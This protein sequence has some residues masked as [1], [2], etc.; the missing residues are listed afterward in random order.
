MVWRERKANLLAA[1]SGKLF[2][3]Q[4]KGWVLG[5]AIGL[6]HHEVPGVLLGFILIDVEAA[7]PFPLPLHTFQGKLARRC[8]FTR[9]LPLR[10]AAE[11]LTGDST[12]VFRFSEISLKGMVHFNAE[13]ASF[14]RHADHPRRTVRRRRRRD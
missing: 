13:P 2:L 4:P 14:S 1:P 7:R 12:G 10:E 5:F 8:F 6:P 11:P 9:Q 3:V